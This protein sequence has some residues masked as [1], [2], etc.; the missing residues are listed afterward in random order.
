MRPQCPRAISSGMLFK[1]LP[2]FGLATAAPPSAGCCLQRLGKHSKKS[3]DIFSALF[4]FLVKAYCHGCKRKSRRAQPV[5]WGE[6]DTLIE[7]ALRR[8][9]AFTWT[10]S[11][12]I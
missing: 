10:A 6:G 7:E 9:E 2:D 8:I 12:T 11:A 3:G 1:Y 4:A 5:P